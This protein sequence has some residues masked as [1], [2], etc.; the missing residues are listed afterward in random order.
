MVPS[1]PKKKTNNN[2]Q[3]QQTNGKNG[4]NS[5]KNSHVRDTA[6]NC[7]CLQ[8]GYKTTCADVITQKKRLTFVESRP[9]TTCI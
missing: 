6:A 2:K 3:Q 1:P 7:S 8:K 9:E 4:Y 5:R